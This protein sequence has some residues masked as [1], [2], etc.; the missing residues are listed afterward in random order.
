MRNILQQLIDLYPTDN[1]EV[2]MES[3]NNA[4]GRLGSLLPGPNTN[5]NAG[6]LQL[7]NTQGVPQEALSICRIAAIRI[8]SA[9]YN[10]AITYL[11]EPSPAP[12]GCNA[13]C[14]A[15]VR[16]YLPVGTTGV[17]INAGGQ[18]VANGRVLINEF[19]VVVI[20][21]NEDS[22]PTFVST[23]EAEIITI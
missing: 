17:N 7:T 10:N 2:S 18:T 1:V 4:S 13:D 12:S 22:S 21:G 9:A 8:T 19:G 16:S 14:E 3:G 11:P 15:A 23:C 5:P 20:V 6:L